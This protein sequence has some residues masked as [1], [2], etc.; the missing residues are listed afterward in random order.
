MP[1]LVYSV[2]NTN[3]EFAKPSFYWTVAMVKLERQKSK[4]GKN[5]GM[6]KVQKF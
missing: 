3:S 5:Y 2:I 1:F 6:S 4:G